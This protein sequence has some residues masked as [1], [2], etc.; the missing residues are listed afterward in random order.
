MSKKIEI[1]I[2]RKTAKITMETLNFQGGECTVE[3]DK[4]QEALGAV[5][6]SVDD[7]PEKHEEVVMNEQQR[8]GH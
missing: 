7:K 2:N 6:H 3:L 1:A 5:Q 4:F 8:L